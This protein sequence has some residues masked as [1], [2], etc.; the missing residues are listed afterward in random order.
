MPNGII[1]ADEKKI[2]DRKIF[3]NVSFIFIFFLLT[4]ANNVQIN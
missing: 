4:V 3:S 2:R 1:R